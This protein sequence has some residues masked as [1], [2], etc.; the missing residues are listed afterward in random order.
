MVA[1]LAIVLLTFGLAGTGAHAATVLVT[2]ESGIAA[3]GL[4]DWGVKGADGS[5]V[6]QPFTIAVPGVP[7]LNVTVSE[8]PG[9]SFKRV[10][11]YDQSSGECFSWIG[12]FGPCEKLLFTGGSPGSNGPITLDF[13]S[14]VRG[15]GAQIQG[16]TIG[17]FTASIEAFDSLNNSLG[18]FTL[19]GNSTGDGDDSAIFIGILSTA[20]D[21]DK[22][23]FG[24]PIS[25]GDPQTFAING[26][27]IQTNGVVPE[28]S[29]LLLLGSGLA[30]LGLWRRRHA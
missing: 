4:I 24:V 18:S 1:A 20:V 6:A 16:S 19:A 26:P 17:L 28:P 15:V 25:I 13:D 7:G 10:D 9:A 3:D 29:S 22:V 21:I 30:G 5:I 12:N 11:Q 27:R 23:V 14:P 2:V 8:A